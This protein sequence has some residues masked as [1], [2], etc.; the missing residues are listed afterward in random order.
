M[1]Q[2]YYLL[3]KAGRWGEALQVRLMMRYGIHAYQ[4]D[5]FGTLKSARVDRDA[6]G[7]EKKWRLLESH[8]PE[9]PYSALDVGCNIGYFSFKMAQ[10]GADH[11]IGFETERGPILVADKLKILGR[12]GNVG[13]L[14]HRITPENI[15]LLGEYDVILFLSVFH[16]LVYAYDLDVAKGMLK[17]LLSRTRRTLFFETG[18]G[19]QEFGRMARAM[20]RVSKEDAGAF[21]EDLLGECGAGHVTKIGETDLKNGATRGLYK[22][23]M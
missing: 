19:D 13:F 1:R 8:L 18:Q 5:P 20:P 4:P 22:V 17:V 12:V 7:T 23:S 2:V 11:V 9:I 16:H 14:V 6:R 10:A 3:A 21:I 15:E